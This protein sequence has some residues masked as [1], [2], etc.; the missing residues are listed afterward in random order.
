MNMLC[1]LNQ[2][3]NALLNW[4]APVVDLAARSWVAWEFSKSGLVKIQSWESTL[5]LFEYEYSVPILPPQLAAITGTAT[6]LIF[7]VLLALGLF[8]R[9]PAT[10][11]FFFNIMAVM[12]Y[13]DISPA[14]VNQ[15]ILWGLIFGLLAVHG[16]GK[17]SLDTL[18]FR[19]CQE[20]SSP[21]KP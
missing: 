9:V 18:L 20:T 19:H 3:L 21:V 7:P 16:S 12:S 15:H 2:L 1:R 14:G 17:L 4:F 11:L 6:E 10:V 5:T 13:P 8:G